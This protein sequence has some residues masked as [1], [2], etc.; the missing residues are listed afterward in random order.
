MS[1]SI[2]L[3]IIFDIY[4]VV[5]TIYPRLQSSRPDIVIDGKTPVP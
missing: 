3:L 4:D 2:P 1:S 5:K